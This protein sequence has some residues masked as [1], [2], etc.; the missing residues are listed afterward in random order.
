MHLSEGSLE[1]KGVNTLSLV[2]I[3]NVGNGKFKFNNLP[4]K[5]QWAPIFSSLPSDYNEDG[6][7]ELLTGDNFHE[8]KPSTGGKYDASY[9]WIQALQMMV[10]L[11]YLIY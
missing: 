11:K 2:Y 10:H 8:V 9:G 5:L 1:K 4:E 7:M 3:E 6:N